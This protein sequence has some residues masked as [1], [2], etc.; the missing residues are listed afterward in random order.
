M[1]GRGGGGGD[2]ERSTS[3]DMNSG[4]PKHNSAT[5]RCT[6]HK[7]ISANLIRMISEG[8]SDT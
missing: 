6:A 7:A 8:S 3:R 2:R 4:C 5:C 1:S